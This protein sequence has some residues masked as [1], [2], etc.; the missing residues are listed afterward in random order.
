MLAYQ[1]LSFMIVQFI[2]IARLKVNP[3]G[4]V[5]HENNV[6]YA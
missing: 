2:I 3:M 5:L 6:R 1:L 4:N